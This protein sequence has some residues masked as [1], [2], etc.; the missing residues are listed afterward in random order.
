MNDGTRMD[1][2]E[3]LKWIAAASAT[4]SVLDLS[5]FAKGVA[6]KGYGTD[7]NLVDSYKPGDFWPLTFTREQHRLVSVLCDVILPADE[8]S[9]SATEL[10]VPDFLDEWVSAPYPYQQSDRELILRGLDWLEG[11]AHRRFQKGFADLTA[12][13]HTQI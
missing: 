2:R 5:S 1:R 7:P 3:A 9:P 4:I 13:Q 6:A 11:E 10:K 12:A 8:K